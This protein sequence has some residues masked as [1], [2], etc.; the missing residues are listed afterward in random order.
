MATAVLSVAMYFLLRRDIESNRRIFANSEKMS[1][2]SFSTGTGKEKQTATMNDKIVK[3][4][5]LTT[6]GQNIPTNITRQMAYNNQPMG[7]NIEFNT[8][9][10]A[11][12]IENTGP[13]DMG[14]V[15]NA[16]R[17]ATKGDGIR[18]DVYVDGHKIPKEMVDLAMFN[19]QEFYNHDHFE[20]GVKETPNLFDTSMNI[21]QKSMFGPIKPVLGLGTDIYTPNTRDTQSLRIA[22]KGGRF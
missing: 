7:Y 20:F 2:H 3:V 12:N 21:P 14:T 13:I 9:P 10:Q 17:N 11:I 22:S 6:G 18:R 1:A 19:N 16:V 15:A 8:D 4:R 5:A